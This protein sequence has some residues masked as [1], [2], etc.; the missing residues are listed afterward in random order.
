MEVFDIKNQE[1]LI[2]FIIFSIIFTSILGTLLH[3]TFNWSNRNFLVGAFSAVNES[4]WEHLKLL[5]FPMLISTIIGYFYIGRDIHNFLCSRALG[6]IS[7]LL[8]VII[9]FYTY[10]GILGANIGFLNIASFF[11]SVIL[12]EY[13]S[14]RLI[15]SH[16]DCNNKKSVVFLV[17]LLFCFLFFTYFPPKIGL[18]RDPITNNYGIIKL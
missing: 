8:F 12:G 11:V 10:T 3:F 5:F 1:K 15:V 2:K 17:I 13:I 7:A 14:Y 6:I 18:F 16:C 9:F 4:S